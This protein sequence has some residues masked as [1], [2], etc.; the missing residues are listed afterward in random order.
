MTSSPIVISPDAWVELKSLPSDEERELKC[1]VQFGMTY[2]EAN[3]KYA[4][5]WLEQNVSSGNIMFT[6]YVFEQ[7]WSNDVV[8]NVTFRVV[9]HLNEK[10]MPDYVLSQMPVATFDWTDAPSIA[11][12]SSSVSNTNSVVTTHVSSPYTINLGNHSDIT[13]KFVLA[14]ISEQTIKTLAL[15]MS[16]TQA[17][18]N[19]KEIVNGFEAQVRAFKKV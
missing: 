15:A 6:S 14:C 4:D 7:C 1:Q 18:A 5:D 9:S 3:K 2:E 11:S 16:K 10:H 12:N 8:L 13:L 19:L 17:Y